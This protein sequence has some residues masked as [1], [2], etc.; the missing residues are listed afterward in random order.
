[1]R[2]ATRKPPKNRKTKSDPAPKPDSYTADGAPI[3][4][5]NPAPAF[6]LAA[7]IRE[8]AERE[9]DP[10]VKTWALKLAS[11]DGKPRQT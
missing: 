6:T 7:V 1:M 10:I 4:L 9:A 11:G 2:T 8:A 5:K 3:E